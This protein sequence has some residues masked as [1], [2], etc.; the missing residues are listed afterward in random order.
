[1][2]LLRF[3]PHTFALVLATSVSAPAG[4]FPGFRGGDGRSVS[5]DRNYPVE[6]GPEKNVRWRVELPGR[7]NGSPVVWGDR[8]F[9]LQPVEKENR[10]TLMCFNRADGKL[11]WQSGVTY[12]EKEAHHPDNPYCSGTPATDGERVYACFGSAGLYCYDFAGKEV[13]RRELG[14]L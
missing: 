7:S 13:W 3:W 6:W 11:L 10:R 2:S 4:N 14:K 12:A 5:S 9:I 8:V 1:M